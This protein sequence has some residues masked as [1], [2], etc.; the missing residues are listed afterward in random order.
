MNDA[1]P[2]D[3]EGILAATRAFTPQRLTAAREMAGLDLTELAERI[4]ATPS[5][6]SQFESGKARPKAET[7]IRLALALGVPPAFFGAP[8]LPALE[9][10]A[11]HFR[12]LRSASAKERRRVAAYGRCVAAL[13]EYLGEYVNF[14]A[15]QLGQLSA[16]A[17][18]ALAGAGPEDAAVVVRDAWQL[19]EGPIS[20]MVVLLEVKGVLPV[21]VPGHSERLDAFSAWVGDTPVVFLTPGKGSASRRRWDCAHEL[22]HLLLHRG[23]EPG[24]ARTEAEADAFAGAFLLPRGPFLA[25]CPRRLDWNRLRALKRRWGV[26]LAAIVRR[27]YD[28]GVFTEATYRRAYVL[29]NQLGWRTGEPDEPR[30]ERPELLQRAVA[31]LGRAGHSLKRIASD[32]CFGEVQLAALLPA[33]DGE[34]LAF[35]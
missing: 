13:A 3:L 19:G 21:E 25:E 27:A 26:S 32:L 16:R 30:M 15:E 6:V 33:A 17:R 8:P 31:L 18:A 22:A 24:A 5:A 23:R 9:P 10:E 34:Q 35:T 4:D 11:C 12:S 29:L 1:V 28:L 20:D 14:P 2:L 7:V